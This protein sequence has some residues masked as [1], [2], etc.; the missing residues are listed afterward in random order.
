MQKESYNPEDA[1]LETIINPFDDFLDEVTKIQ[2]AFKPLG[3]TV[4]AYKK[5][6]RTLTVIL[7]RYNVYVKL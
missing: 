7:E 4:R 5:K 6:R 2:E 1:K 3:L